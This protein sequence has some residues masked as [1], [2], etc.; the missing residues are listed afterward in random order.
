MVVAGND[1]DLD[2][3]NCQD[4]TKIVFLMVML[5][6]VCFCFSIFRGRRGGLLP[7]LA[8]GNLIV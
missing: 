8:V 4:F 3:E 5:I 1:A 6:S 2:A 7:P